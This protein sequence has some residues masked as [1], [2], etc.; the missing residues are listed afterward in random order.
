M[1]GLE[2]ERRVGQ[3]A[4]LLLQRR[5]HLAVRLGADVV[6]MIMLAAGEMTKAISESA[7]TGGSG[8]PVT[9]ADGAS[10]VPLF[11]LLLIRDVS[12]PAAPAYSGYALCGQH[13]EEPCLVAH[14][15]IVGAI[16]SG[17]RGAV[18]A[19]CWVN[20]DLRNRL[21]AVVALCNGDHGLLSLADHATMQC[22]TARPWLAVFIVFGVLMID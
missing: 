4:E 17:S 21:L 14:G 19:C 11:G 12:A 1:Y 8:C 10:P 6:Q 22:F 2:S 16:L 18:L 3:F 5:S 15:G 9:P 13:G 7:S 20:S